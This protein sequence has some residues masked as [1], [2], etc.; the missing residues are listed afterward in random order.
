MGDEVLRGVCS[1][2][3]PRGIAVEGAISNRN[4]SG[5]AQ[6]GNGYVAVL[7]EGIS[8]WLLCVF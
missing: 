5:I 1:N 2:G 7:L 4:Y 3:L 6:S 8:A